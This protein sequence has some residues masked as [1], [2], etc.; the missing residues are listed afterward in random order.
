MKYRSIQ[1]A[2][3]AIAAL[4]LSGCGGGSSPAADTGA[5]RFSLP[6]AMVVEAPAQ[7]T[8]VEAYQRPP[9]AAAALTLK[10][11]VFAEPAIRPAPSVV[12]LA[13]LAAAAA[14]PG[15][16]K[17]GQPL[18]IGTAREVAQSADS[19]RMR[20]LLQFKPGANGLGPTA[21][22]S[23]TSPGA[24]GLR[25]GLRV[26]DLPAAARVRGYAQGGATAFDLPGSDILAA[27]QRN[28]DA[29]DASEHGRTFWT[30]PVESEE[31]TLEI[32]L[33]AGASADAVKVSVPLLSHVSV[34]AQDLAN[35]MIG[36]AD[37]CEIDVSCTTDVTA[38]SRATARMIFTDFGFSYACT[39]TLLNDTQSSGTPYFLSANHCIGSQTIAS[40][41]TTYWSYKS[42]SCNVVALDTAMTQL[43]GGATLLYSTTATD[44]S[45]MRLNRQPPDSAVF[46]GWSTSPPQ[47]GQAVVGIHNPRGD[48]QKVS[49]GVVDGYLSC[50]AGRNDSFSCFEASVNGGSYL[51]PIWNSGTVESGSSGSGLFASING[52]KYLVGQLKGGDA[53]CEDPLGLNVYG[54]FDLAYTAALARWLSPGTIT[55]LASQSGAASMPRVAVY[56]F[57][58]NATSAHF[59]TPIVAERDYVIANFAPT[60]T[61]EGVAF[62]A[63]ETQVTGSQPVYRLYNR[64]NRR[65]FYTMSRDERDWV[66]A[67]FPEVTNEGIA[68]Y[69]QSG[70][71]GTAVPVFRFYAAEKGAHFY[72]INEAERASIVADHG[73][74]APEGI[75]YYAWTT[76]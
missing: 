70:S 45:F 68:W 73:A 62:Y 20:G 30:P 69:S 50:T 33:P 56:R 36:Q 14:A 31:V 51:S 76:Q 41:L 55:S 66:L 17:A 48:L 39:G 72:T 32:A 34:K 13:R 29:G 1:A 10:R 35:L 49:R 75:A 9:T 53:S 12:R 58:N 61:Y 16:P 11:E 37:T 52:G 27:I 46:A 15:K 67:T 23:F 59:F 6:P 71:G 74:Y 18:R 38:Q 4:A 3:L 63:Y 47:A 5:S 40:T 24:A 44:T 65:H 7:V 64:N 26:E 22:V 54:R 8:Q 60:Y 19:Q 57:Y 21:A 43:N 42:P 2:M 25:L 28:R